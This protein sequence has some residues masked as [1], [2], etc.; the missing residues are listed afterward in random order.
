MWNIQIAWKIDTVSSGAKTK[1]NIKFNMFWTGEI[2]K[3]EDK[4]QLKPKTFDRLCHDV[5]IAI[6][7][8]DAATTFKEN[9]DNLQKL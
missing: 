1:E 4:D 6:N 7:E 9:R 5:Q 3:M 2:E 8:K